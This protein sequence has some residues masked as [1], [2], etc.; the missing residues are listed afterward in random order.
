M[1]WAPGATSRSPTSCCGSTA[2]RWRLVG[3]RARRGAVPPLEENLLLVEVNRLDASRR[4]LESRVE[5]FTLQ[6]KALAAWPAEAALTLKGDLGAP[7][8]TID[9]PAGVAQALE[10]RA[11]LRAAQ[12]D[13]AMARAKIL[14]EQAE[15]RWDASI[16]RQLPASGLRLRA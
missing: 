5:V 4:M 15:G 6:L 1:C 9:R 16:S 14:K 10:Q 2:R 11:D 12:A 8:P 3:E 13:A 7:P